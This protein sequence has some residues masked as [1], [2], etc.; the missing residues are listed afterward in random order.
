MDKIKVII[1]ADF[2]FTY[3]P[4][5]F[6]EGFFYG[7]DMKEVINKIE[8]EKRNENLYITEIKVLKNKE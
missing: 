3:Y 1:W 6:C 8:E 4:N 7:N 2:K 5:K